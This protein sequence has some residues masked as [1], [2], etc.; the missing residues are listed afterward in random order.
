M[1]NTDIIAIETLMIEMLIIISLIAILV[2]RIHL[3]YTVALVLSGLVLAVLP[4]PFENLNL[5]TDLI[6]FL[7]LPPLVFEAAFH[8]DIL[9][10]REHL[11]LIVILAV[12]GVLI[13]TLVVGGIVALAGVPLMIA[14][15]FGALIS[16]TD[17]V[18]VIA[19]FRE[20]GVPRKL[21]YIVEGES[22]LNDGIAI[23]AFNIVLTAA[24][25]G[26]FNLTQGL[27]DF[28][29]VTGGGI[30]IGAVIGVVANVVFLRID[31][32]LIETTLSTVVAYGAFVL[33]E[34]L[35]VSGVIAVVTAGLL[36]GN[37]G[38]QR[39][40]SPSTRIVVEN[41]WEYVAFIANSFVFLL[42]GLTIDLPL[43]TDNLLYIALG[44]VAVLIGRAIAVYGLGWLADRPR[45]RLSMTYRHVLFWGGLRG[46]IALA[47][48][49][50]LPALPDGWRSSL[51]AMTFGVVLFTLI[52]QSTT[53]K[54]LLDRLGLVLVQPQRRQ[55]ELVRAR[56]YAVQAAEDQLQRMH[57]AGVLSQEVWQ[58]LRDEYRTTTNDLSQQIQR[59]H[60]DDISLQEEEMLAARA[61]GLRSQRTALHNLVRR[62]LLS[63]HSYQALATEIDANL[64]S[65]TGS[66]D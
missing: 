12:V 1:E 37:Y 62:G 5:T 8:L 31:N 7:I 47:L 48:A 61:D 9:E 13:S 29:L 50:S 14:L 21:S 19:V 4:T 28:L 41:F 10:L 49:L 58:A 23:V 64:E 2:Q 52:I 51:L 24:L 34:R 26:S 3:P 38:S 44:I 59:M 54:P 40:M 63:E 15:V 66:H 11:G 17:P 56:M 36:V 22:L 16:A 46:A 57:R 30:L 32:Y 18:A 65:L 25:S 27:A 33:A 42:I 53:I 6:L 43:L 55:Y 20:L 60:A 39:S 35:H 45:G